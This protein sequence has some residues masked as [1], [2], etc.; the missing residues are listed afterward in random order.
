MKRIIKLFA[1]LLAFSLFSVQLFSFSAFAEGSSASVGS[2]SAESACL[3]DAES[4]RVL[5]GKSERVRMPMASTTKIMTALIALES[6]IPLDTAVTVPQAAVGV[7]GSSMYLVESERI[8]FESLLY[9]L[10]LCSANDA[11]VAI[12]IA[13][14]GSVEHFVDLMNE[15]A[16]SLGL[17]DTH[18]TNP[19]GLYDD[20]HYTSAYDLA[21]LLS[22]AMKNEKFAAIS[23]CEKKVFPKGEDGVRVMINHNRLLSQYDGVIGGKT[24]FTKKSGRCLATCAERD[25][26]RLVAVTLNAPNDWSDHASLYDFGFSSYEMVNFSAISL[27]IPVISGKKGE[28]LAKTDGFSLLLPRER[29]ELEVRI[30]APRF[31]FADVDKGDELGRAVYICNGRIIATTPLYAYEDVEKIHYKFNLF[32]WLKDLFKGLFD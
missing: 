20:E 29:G 27:Q 2:L 8:T 10:L 25:G 28:I 17:S 26:L 14:G 3:I 11:A 13:V 21:L 22:H 6:G 15:K 32:E 4:G 23:G 9:G 7:E 24:G 31:V 1:F 12:S 16:A 30:E 5:F 18:F 19:H